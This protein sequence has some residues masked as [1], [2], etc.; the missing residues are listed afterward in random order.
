MKRAKKSLHPLL[1]AE[2]NLVTKDQDKAEVLNAFFAPKAE[3]SQ[4]H[5]VGWIAPRVWKELADVVAKPLSIILRQSWLTRNVPVDWRL[6]NVRVI[7]KK[8]W[9]DDPGSYR[10]I[11]LNLGVGEGYGTDNLGSHHRPVK[12]QPRDQAQS[13]WVYK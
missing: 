12:G 4:V 9:K 13:A 5:G 8:G 3:C 1:D 7:F 10:P 6:A 2:G 11:S